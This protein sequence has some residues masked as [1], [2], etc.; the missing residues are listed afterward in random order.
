HKFASQGRDPAQPLQ[1]VQNH[2]FAGKDDARVMAHYRNGLTIVQPYSVENLGMTG[3]F[4][5]RCYGSIKHGIHIENPRYATDSSENTILFRNN[6]SGRAL[7]GIDAGI[8]RRVAG[9]AIFQQ[10]VL[11]NGR[12]A[13]TV[14]IHNLARN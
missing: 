6:G 4:V 7:A 14:P 13:A 12:Y 10:R 2:A 8:T 9:G 5:M 11:N 1:E 3:Y